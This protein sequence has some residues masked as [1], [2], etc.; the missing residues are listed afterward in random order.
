MKTLA[1][2]IGINTYPGKASLI[3]AINDAE[4][5]KDVFCRRGYDVIFAKDCDSD[6]CGKILHEFEQTLPRYDASIFYFAGHGFEMEGEN[7]L[8]SADC[9]IENATIYMCNRTCIR[10]TELFDIYVR[11]QNK[12]H[13]VILDACRLP[14]GR[15]SGRN[16]ATVYGPKGTLIAFSTSPFETA[17][18]GGADGHSIYTSA[19][20]KNIGREY[21]T[22]EKLFKN[23]RKTVHD[24]SGS[25]QTTWEH[26]SLIGDFYFNTGQLVHS[27]AIPYDENVVKDKNYVSKG[28][29]VGN[30]VTELKSQNWDRQNNAMRSLNFLNPTAFNKNELFIIGRNILQA[31]GSAFGASDFLKEAATNLHLYGSNNENHLLNGILFEI[32]FDSTGEFRKGNFKQNR[33][34]EIFALRQDPRF[35]A[36]FDFIGAALASYRDYLYYIPSAADEIIDVNVVVTPETRKDILDQQQSIQVIEKVTSNGIDITEDLTRFYLDEGGEASLKKILSTYMAAPESV[37]QIH[38]NSELKQ[39]VFRRNMVERNPFYNW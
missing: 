37:I 30:I 3:N 27:V 17:K 18:D 21:L 31:S 6:Q 25:T 15:G 5:I 39:I 8:A 29:E 23:V 32:Y 35:K 14:V 24:L 7:F 9:P 12:V 34:K 28:D 2:V 26:T 16:L 33:L 4:A 38:T 10:L 36:S 20:L 1:V 13:I 19:L 11:Q 22:V